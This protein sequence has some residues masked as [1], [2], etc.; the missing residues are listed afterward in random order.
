MKLGFSLPVRNE[1]VE[2]KRLKLPWSEDIITEPNARDS[3]RKRWVKVGKGK[4][5]FCFSEPV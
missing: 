4:R 5:Y 2:W 1:W 3:G